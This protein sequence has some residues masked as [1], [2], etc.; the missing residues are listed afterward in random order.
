MTIHLPWDGFARPVLL[1]VLVPALLFI[2]VALWTAA[3]RPRRR[4]LWLALAIPRAILV[5][6]LV[7]LAAGPWVWEEEIRPGRLEV[8]IDL[9][10]SEGP[11]AAER[12]VDLLRSRMSDVP[13]SR[14]PTRWVVGGFAENGRILATGTGLS[15]DGATALASLK[16]RDVRALTGRWSSDPR[17]LA[18]S[19]DAAREVEEDTTRWIVTDGA[20]P[21][22]VPRPS[23]PSFILPSRSAASDSGLRDLVVE[24]TMPFPEGEPVVLRLAFSG[25]EP[26]PLAWTWDGEQVKTPSAIEKGGAPSER[27]FQLPPEWLTPGWHRV[28]VRTPT[29]PYAV[30]CALRVIPKRR[31]IYVTRDV[32]TDSAPLRALRA[33]QMGVDPMKPEMLG[34]ALKDKERISAVILDRLAPE[35]VTPLAEKELVELVHAGR[36][37]WLIPRSRRGDFLAWSRRPLGR[38]LPVAGLPPPP[39]TPP[40]SPRKP[41][42][43]PKKG[44][45][46]PDPK[47]SH[48]EER[49]AP[50]LILLLVIDKSSSMKDGSRLHFAKQGAIA[51]LA[52]LHPEDR[53]GVISYNTEPT[54]VVPVQ[55]VGERE[56]IV[57]SIRRIRAQGGTDI[58]RA[59]EFAK[60]VLDREE[61]AV[62]TVVLLSDGQ[63]PAFDIRKVCE[64]LVTSGI[65]VNTIGVGSNF[66][67]GTLT[68][69]AKY[70]RGTGPIPAHS[71][72][73]IPAVMV[74]LANRIV[75]EH[76]ARRPEDARAKKKDDMVRSRNTKTDGGPAKQGV[77]AATKPPKARR[78]PVKLKRPASYLV[79]LDV[80]KI[81]PL[82][83]LHTTRA[84]DAAWVSLVAG[85]E[86]PLLAHWR[87]S[88]GWVAASTAPVEGSWG[89][90]WPLFEGYARLV[91]QIAAFLEERRPSPPYA[92]RAV[93]QDD[94]VLVSVEPSLDTWRVATL[95]DEHGETLEFREGVNRDGVRL[96]R[97]SHP[98]HE[99]FLTLDLTGS[100]NTPHGSIVFWMPPS[101]ELEPVSSK[102]PHALAERWASRV[103][104]ASA[105]TSDLLP[106]PGVR[107]RRRPVALAWIPSL[108]LGFGLELLL[109]RMIAR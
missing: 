84:K 53:I 2:G 30:G 96:L 43:K 45:S 19:L 25:E 59:L 63:T 9:S 85:T 91:A 39:E 20:L 55:P 57:R 22:G 42:T 67:R 13:R 47:K 5:A 15:G 6:A 78:F 31:L 73:H 8:M 3:R 72:S 90:A 101:R 33:Q 86:A 56:R 14:P 34:E 64:S 21:E 74:D 99:T 92:L 32:E 10:A 71:S 60:R 97:L 95:R 50:T 16:Q 105:A 81:P 80:A 29:A 98:V 18:V 102:A 40:K 24:G 107:R 82:S 103:V 87:T 100:D 4:F 108:L 69:I 88:G 75:R 65:S 49:E 38:L 27:R 89:Q 7:V 76:G 36:G 52:R 54:E 58:K 79:G 17:G 77:S 46:R 26:P 68:Q 62:K 93:G 51:T 35:D 94:L 106:R 44:L 66:D 28:V 104:D 41:K 23:V 61:A 11:D 37:L 48:E 12:A 109:K 83:G 70:G 1:L